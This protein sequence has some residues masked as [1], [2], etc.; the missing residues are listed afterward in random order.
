MGEDYER[1]GGRL[2]FIPRSEA[3]SYLDWLL[4]AWAVCGQ[5]VTLLSGSDLYR[6]IWKKSRDGNI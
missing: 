1:A 5:E 6:K 2:G 3:A 4:P